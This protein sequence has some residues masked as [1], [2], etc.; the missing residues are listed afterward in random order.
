[1][2]STSP[3]NQLLNAAD[4]RENFIL[5]SCDHLG[6]VLVL[7]A[8]ARSLPTS[9]ARRHIIANMVEALIAVSI[10]FIVSLASFIAFSLC[11]TKSGTVRFTRSCSVYV[12]SCAPLFSAPDRAL[13]SADEMARREY[14]TNGS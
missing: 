1:M 12:V 11:N 4:M 6:A 14:K 7:V 8:F 5:I 10:V 13:R 9:I 2:I 3:C